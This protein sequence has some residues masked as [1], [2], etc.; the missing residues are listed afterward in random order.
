MVALAELEGGHGLPIDMNTLGSKL[1]FV[2]KQSTHENEPNISHPSHH[3]SIP[4]KESSKST[5]KKTA[6]IRKGRIS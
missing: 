6:M 4:A 5:T 3:P 2:K 1:Q